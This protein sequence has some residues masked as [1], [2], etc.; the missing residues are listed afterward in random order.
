VAGGWL[1]AA[2][3]LIT[4][5]WQVEL[6]GLLMGGLTNF[7][8][9]A[10]D[11]WA[12]PVV[13]SGSQARPARS[14]GSFPG[15]DDYGE[16]MVEAELRIAGTTYADVQASRRLLAA[17]W[18][19]PASGTVPLIWMEDDGVKY[20]VD[21]KPNLADPR[22]QP[23]IPTKAMFVASDPRIYNNTLVQVT[24]P[25]PT[26]SGGL[27]FSAAAPF[28]FGTGGTGGSLDC[29][30]NGNIETPYVVVFTGPLVA[31]TIEHTAQAKILAF[32]GTLAAGESLVVD[33]ASRTVLLNGVSS[34]YSW[35]IS[36][37]WFTLEPGPNGLRFSGGSGTGSVQ[38][39]YRHAQL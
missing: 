10:F 1:M 31:P 18:K 5:P 7:P 26:S 30:N 22:V 38:V 12:A 25:F 29:P 39:S 33:S 35:L 21:G 4:V 6:N 32:T 19:L 24:A 27:L 28:V 15:I 9:V 37:Q 2:G 14:K 20:R 17:A 34:R 13:R 36:P 11:P 8:F 23:N 16:R 3:D